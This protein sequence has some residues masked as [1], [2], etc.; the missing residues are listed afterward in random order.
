MIVRGSIEIK[1]AY[2]GT[3]QARIGTIVINCEFRFESR[4]LALISRLSCA[5]T[6][7]RFLTRGIDDQGDVAT[8]VETEQVSALTSSP[9]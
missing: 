4:F 6:G 5:R 7:S 1:T 9:L 2:V 3:Q 8:F